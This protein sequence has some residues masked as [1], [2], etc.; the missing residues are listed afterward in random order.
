MIKQ[1][2]PM[3][4]LELRNLGLIRVG[5]SRT[6]ST[7]YDWATKANHATNNQYTYHIAKVRSIWEL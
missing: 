1:M 6:K 2:V 5:A 4:E 3:T 7:I